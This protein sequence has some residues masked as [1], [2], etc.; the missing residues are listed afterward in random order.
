MTIAEMRTELS[1]AFQVAGMPDPAY[2]ARQIIQEV[3][4]LSSSDLLVRSGEAVT[5]EEAAKLREWLAARLQ[6]MPLAYLTGRKGFYKHEF[7]VGPGVLVPRPETELVVETALRR[8]TPPVRRL[9]D[10]G[11][12][13]GCIGLSLLHEI[14]GS[15]LLGI[16]ASRA[17]YD[18]SVSNAKKLDLSPRTRFFTGR[19]EQ[20]TPQSSADLIVANPPYIADGDSS[21]ERNVHD[22]EPHEALY[23][24]PSGLEAIYLWSRWAHQHLRT[25]GWFVCEF[26]AGQ[27]RHVQ[28]IISEQGFQELEISRDLAGIERVISAKK[29]R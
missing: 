4:C 3:L 11:C 21:V 25:G 18:C 17:A 1:S 19:V 22:H 23:S 26:G 20:W 27:S 10:L 2:E 14:P 6:G 28:E 29:V 15:E 13:S 24:G 12:G 8:M 7:H 16:D 9:M 5:A